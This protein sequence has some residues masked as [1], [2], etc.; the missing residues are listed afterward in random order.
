MIVKICGI[1][2]AQDAAAAV[3]AGATALG[4]NFYPESPRFVTPEQA[5][6]I[7]S[8]V[9][10]EVLKVGVFVNEPAEAV[11][12]LAWELGLDVVQLYGNCSEWPQGVRVWRA[13]RVTGEF[14]AD[15]IGDPRA[16]ALLLDAA[17]PGVW[18]G[19]GQSFD[20]RLA[21]GVRARIVIAGGLDESNV[22]EAI[23]QARPWGV[24]ACSRLERAPGRKDHERMRRFVQAALAAAK[25]GD[26]RC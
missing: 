5:A 2:N 7:L 25:Q 9:P 21:R 16:E 15:E 18:G 23:R 12:N 20:W 11:E 22:A 3:E 14:R 1:T 24:D 8:V 4:V 19:S 10:D 26:C 17:P 6:H 13:V